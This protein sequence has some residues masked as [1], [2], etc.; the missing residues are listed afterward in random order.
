VYPMSK[1]RLKS[2]TVVWLC[3]CTTLASG[4]YTM[5][6]TRVQDSFRDPPDPQTLSSLLETVLPPTLLSVSLRSRRKNGNTGLRGAACS[7]GLSPHAGFHTSCSVL[8]AFP[9][10]ILL[11]EF[12]YHTRLQPRHP[13]NSESRINTGK[14]RSTEHDV[15]KPACGLKDPSSKQRLGY[16]YYHF[17]DANAAIRRECGRQPRFPEDLKVF[18]DLGDREKNLG[19]G[20]AHCVRARGKRGALAQPYYCGTL[21]N[22]TSTLGT[23]L[24]AS[25]YGMS[26]RIIQ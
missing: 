25:E 21:S 9:V 22:G 7:T 13:Q 16:R 17:S 12:V 2:S 15:W 6:Q 26:A 19:R 20:L 14:A 8:R 11:S 4:S 18:E 3:E 5:C 23:R 24:S 10:L 1:Y